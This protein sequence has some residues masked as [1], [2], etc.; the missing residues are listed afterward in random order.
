MNTYFLS[1]LQPERK[2]TMFTPQYS[3]YG[4]RWKKRNLE[5]RKSFSNDYFIFVTKSFSLALEIFSDN[6]YLFLKH[7]IN[8]TYA[9]E[10]SSHGRIL[11]CFAGINF[12]KKNFILRLDLSSFLNIS[13]FLEESK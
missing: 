5:F 13:R 3:G 9:L 6:P 10:V 2:R 1:L 8:K 7:E 4:L 12:K 11:V